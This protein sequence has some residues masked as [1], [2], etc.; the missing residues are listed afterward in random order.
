VAS[1]DLFRPAGPGKVRLQV[2]LTPKASANRLQDVT[3]DLVLKVQV[4][5]VPENGKANQA[6][7]ALL[8]KFWKLPKSAFEITSGAT[9]RNKVLLIEGD[10][11]EL[12][13]R[14]DREGISA[15]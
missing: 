5:A 9:D 12:A 10:A 4:T 1:L 2:R 14:L 8:A 6:L 7:I 11:D 15:S 3:P 13:A